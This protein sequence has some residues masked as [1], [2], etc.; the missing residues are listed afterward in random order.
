MSATKQKA[1]QAEAKPDDAEPVDRVA[2]IERLA[3]LDSV[4]YEVARVEAA[5]R[6]GMR[7]SVLDAEV[8]KTRRKLRL[9]KQDDD[10]NGQGRPV[11]VVDA[12]PWHEPVDGDRLATTLSCAA[13]SHVAM[14]DAAADAVALWCL[15]TWCVDAF[16]VTPRLCLYSATK[17][18]GKTTLLGVVAKLTKRPKF[19]GSITPAALFRVVELLR[20]TLIVDEL[21]K[22]L[23]RNG[24]LHLLLNEGHGRG[25]N[26]VRLVGDAHEPREFAVFAPVAF[27][28][29]GRVPDDLEDRSIV[30]RL[31]R[32]RAGDSV[33][34]FREDK[35][36]HLERLARMC[37]RWT[38]N[39]AEAIVEAADEVATPGLANRTADN[40]RPLFAIAAVLGADW[41][42]RCA[43]AAAALEGT[44]DDEAIGTML[45]GDIRGV[46]EAEKADKLASATLCEKL[47]AIEGRPWQE[48]HNGKPLSPNR[49]ARLL[50][51]FG[52]IPEN[53]RVGGQVPKGYQ[54]AHF[55][56][57][58]ER[59]FAP[60]T[61]Q[62]TATTPQ[63]Y[64]HADFCDF[65]TATAA[66]G[67]AVQKCEKTASNGHCSDVAGS[68]RVGI[69]NTEISS[70][71]PADLCALCGW[72]GKATDK[73]ECWEAHGQSA[74]LH[75]RCQDAWLA[76]VTPP[77]DGAD[78]VERAG[79]G[80]ARPPQ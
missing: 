79:N 27:G 51:P 17:G 23:E 43:E 7:P 53:I 22:F 28:T 13:R 50:K 15:H 10:D 12:V 20:P 68:Q 21:G 40:W 16:A 8:K 59:Y 29:L 46:F 56:D 41:P 73:L 24:E 76:S 72:P 61:P 38:E 9:D 26:V 14:P 45:L 44:R 54:L 2:E 65:E 35:A 60:P 63:P 34:P 18:C 19:A 55:A 69:P 70:F 32:K 71:N 67:V 64:S 52:V 74:W 66:D 49:L 25:L 39:N 3:A 77:A 42:Q 58:F 6:L 4:N 36:E 33:T 57:A 47:A 31:Q 30:V 78:A 11:Q 80:R 62:E 37:A 75:T 5:K 1:K 48:W